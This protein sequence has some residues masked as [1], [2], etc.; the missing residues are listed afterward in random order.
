MI[1]LSVACVPR[2]AQ[3]CPSVLK[4][5]Q[6]CPEVPIPPPDSAQVV[7]TVPKCAQACPSVPRVTTLLAASLLRSGEYPP[8]EECAGGSQRSRRQ[9]GRLLPAGG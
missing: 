9:R 3:A 2:C 4:C 7:R 5:A 1:I 6:A 8:A